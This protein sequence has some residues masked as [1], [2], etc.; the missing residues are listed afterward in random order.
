MPIISVINEKGGVGKTTVASH[1]ARGLQKK[2]KDVLLIDSDPQGSLRDWYESAGENNNLP[3]VISMDRPAQFKDINAV[4]KDWTIIDGAPSIQT[5]SIAAIKISD[6]VIIPVHPS[7]YDV[8]AT[9]SLVEVIKARLQISD[10]PKA[11]FMISRQIIG[12]KLSHDVTEA[13][14][15]YGFDILDSRT[16][17]RV[18]FPASAAKGSTA[19]DEEPNGAAAKEI[20]QL[21]DEVIKWAS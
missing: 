7:P 18:I 17:Q 19:I 1:L 2:G 4:A 8:W 10:K 16:T 12:T 5:L 6:F 20:F 13:L 11:A 14:K 3:P 9:E 21:V 15:D